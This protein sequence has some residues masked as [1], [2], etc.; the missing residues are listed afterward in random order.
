MLDSYYSCTNRIKFHIKKLTVEHYRSVKDI[1]LEQFRSNGVA[2]SDLYDS[3]KSRS[4]ELSL[5]VLNTSGDLVGFALVHNNYTSF[6]AFHSSYQKMNLGS[7][8]I[9]NILKKCIRDK[10]SMYLY[11]LQQ[12]QKLINWYGS[13]GFYKTYD[14]YLA[15]HSY[16]T[17]RQL[18]FIKKLLS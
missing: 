6:I 5:A 13:H 7:M 11:P 8:L 14:G 18:P 9:T 3:W 2:P 16:H 15:F 4:R 17:R 12:R 10:Q 1:F